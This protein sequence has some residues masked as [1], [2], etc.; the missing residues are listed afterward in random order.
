MQ[1]ITK[2]YNSNSLILAV[3]TGGGENIII[4]NLVI[5]TLNF[6]K[7]SIGRKSDLHNFYDS[8]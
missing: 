4:I 1:E 3:G 8:L 6:F 5:K 7:L 2:Y